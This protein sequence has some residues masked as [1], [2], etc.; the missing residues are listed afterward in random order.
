MMVPCLNSAFQLGFHIRGCK[1]GLGLAK[2][3]LGFNSRITISND[4]WGFR[5][6]VVRPKVRSCNKGS[7]LMPGLGS[8]TI[9]RVSNEGYKPESWLH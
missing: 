3:G 1:S 6:R 8:E 5:I 9:I 7:G 2:K 4:S